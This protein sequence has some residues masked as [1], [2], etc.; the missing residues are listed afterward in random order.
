MATPLP[1]CM[2]R[3][4]IAALD[5]FDRVLDEPGLFKVSVWIVTATSVSSAT[6]RQ[7]SIAAGVVPQSS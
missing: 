5:R 4:D 7:L 3:M 6:D 1:L 2:E